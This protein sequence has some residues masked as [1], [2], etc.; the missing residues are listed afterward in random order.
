MKI[1]AAWWRG[2]TSPKERSDWAILDVHHYH[3]WEPQCQGAQDGHAMANYTCAISEERRDAL[4][5]C[6]SWATIFRQTVDEE[7]GKGAQL[8]SGEMSASTHHRVRHACNDV[9]T[10]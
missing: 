5:R 7:C 8:M 3:A 4:Q 6:S 10:L 9:T 1:L 2:A